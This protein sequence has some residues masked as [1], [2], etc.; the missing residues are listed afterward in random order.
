MMR[1][2]TG[3]VG[4]LLA[5][6]VAY[7][8][9]RIETL[10]DHQSAVPFHVPLITYKNKIVYANNRTRE[11]VIQDSIN[12]ER[13]H[14]ALADF[15]NG[16]INV[17]QSSGYAA[18]CS[19]SGS[20]LVLFNILNP[21][22]IRRFDFPI[23]DGD[24]NCF[25]VSVRQISNDVLLLYVGSTGNRKLIKGYY[26][27]S[28]NQMVTGR[29][30]QMVSGPFNIVQVG[31]KVFTINGRG[32]NVASIPLVFDQMNLA[33]SMG[34]PMGDTTRSGLTARYA[35]W[36]IH[37][38]NASGRVFYADPYGHVLHGFSIAQPQ[39]GDVLEVP[40]KADSVKAILDFRQCMILVGQATDLKA[41]DTSGPNDGRLMISVLRRD[42]AG[43]FNEV[44]TKTFSDSFLIGTAYA[45]IDSNGTITA[46]H[47]WG[48]SRVYRPF[49]T[50]ICN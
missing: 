37:P 38:N 47:A 17:D 28:K 43:A 36:I 40:F 14:V 29:V 48:I 3:F 42:Q 11:L 8:E 16:A 10:V 39:A 31:S 34:D 2:G 46:S 23:F 41:D 27:I 21:S 12:L 44:L 13:K 19:Q 30:R 32:N 18:I 9:T 4:A 15:G 1:W 5:T 33:V 7:A 6:T 22:V 49:D 45:G 26:M 20:R 24:D 50:S 35:W 25:G